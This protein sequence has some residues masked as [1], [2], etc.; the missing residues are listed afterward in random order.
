MRILTLE[1][2]FHD[3]RDVIVALTELYKRDPLPPHCYLVYDLI[4]ELKSV[5][6]ILGVSGDVV[7]SYVLIW[8]GPGSYGIHL[9]RPSRDLVSRLA[10]QPDRVAYVLVYE[11]EEEHVL[12]VERRLKDLGYLRVQRKVFHD[13]VC[14]E[15]TFSPS[16][17]EGLAVKLGPR[18]AELFADLKRS[19]GQELSLEEAREILRKRRYYGV[20]IDGKLVS[21]A[22]RYV[23][24]Q[25]IH[26]IGDVYTRPEYRGRG[27]AKAATS[28]ITREAVASGAIASLHV[29]SANEPAIRVYRRLGYHI[30]KTYPWIEAHPR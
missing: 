13:M 4:Y 18:H 20:I 29:E 30:S 19:R 3:Y 21:T 11:G 8:R 14:T 28:A 1:E 7:E 17:N 2:V 27:Y 22:S 9:W 16:A 5:D 26:V 25:E 12:V 24:L 23:A 15:D 10:V 6:V